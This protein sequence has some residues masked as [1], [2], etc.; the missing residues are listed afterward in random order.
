MIVVVGPLHTGERWCF[1]TSRLGDLY[2]PL[3]EQAF[4]GSYSRIAGP[5]PEAYAAKVAAT[6]NQNPVVE[7]YSADRWRVG[8]LQRRIRVP[9]HWLGTFT[10]TA[11]MTIVS[12]ECARIVLVN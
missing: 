4:L 8:P 5:C 1:N 10:Q 3:Q 12:A 9:E 7:I 11:G 2:G 6:M